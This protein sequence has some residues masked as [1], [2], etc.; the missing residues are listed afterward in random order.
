MALPAHALREVLPLPEVRRSLQGSMAF[1]GTMT[2]RGGLVPVLSG[3]LLMGQPPSVNRARNRPFWAPEIHVPH[4]LAVVVQ[5][6][7]RVL[8]VAVDTVVGME[9][10][11]WGARPFHLGELVSLCPSQRVAQAG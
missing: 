8:V 5:H 1:R 4:E 3:R 7:G 2:Y 11:P 10:R 9:A 6:H